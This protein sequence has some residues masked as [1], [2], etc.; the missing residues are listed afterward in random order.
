MSIQ[1]SAS[2][3]DDLV[4]PL[5]CFKSPND[6]LTELLPAPLF[7]RGVWTGYVPLGTVEVCISP[8]QRE[9]RFGFRVDTCVT[10]SLARVVMAA[11][12]KH[13]GQAVEVLLA[14]CTGSMVR[15]RSL[16][17]AAIRNCPLD[18]Y[19][20]W[21]AR[22][23]RAPEPDGLEQ[24]RS[25][26]RQ[27]PHIR[28]IVQ[29]DGESSPADIDATL[30]S[31]RRQC[32]VNWSLAAVCP[33]QHRRMAADVVAAKMGAEFKVDL[34]QP[35]SPVEVLWSAVTDDVLLMP[36][37]AG[38]II[39]SFG[40]SVLAEYAVAHPDIEIIY[41]DEDSAENGKYC[42]PKLKPDWSPTFQRC[43]HYVG[44]AVYA[45]SSIFPRSKGAVASDVALD[46]WFASSILLPDAQVGHL[47]RVLLTTRMHGQKQRAESPRF[48]LPVRRQIDQTTQQPSATIV[49]PNKDRAELLDACLE[50]LRLTRP[51]DFEIIVM[52]NGSKEAE[53]FA[54]Y[55]RWR[56]HPGFR[57]QSSPGPFNFSSLCNLAA[58][59]AR[60]PVLV[61]LNNDT[62]VRTPDW[63]STMIYWTLRPEIGAVGTKLI[64]PSGQLQ[65][66]GLVIGLGGYAAHI[67]RGALSGQ[68]G[69]LGRLGA[70]REVSAV[71]AACMAVERAKFDFV[72]GF[73]AHRFPVEFNDTDLCLRL[74]VAGWATI[75]LVEP[76]LIHHESATRGHTLDMDTRYE[77]ERDYF[78]DR[79]F[80][81]IRDD[82]FFH[83]ALSLHTVATALDE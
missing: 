36:L 82:P 4:R 78:R 41:A 57:V 9:G 16:I 62:V 12:T 15:A 58:A 1:Y 27:G 18:S 72:G 63:L 59:V 31:L 70:A 40:L 65:H 66:A 47:R 64:Y 6:E 25:D 39:P 51:L 24:S 73:D 14:A 44:R 26:R 48:E 68:P 80:Q 83:P 81:C 8:V 42:N 29:L 77:R 43:T 69:Y 34:V 32:Y 33:E 20:S 52:D 75:C 71:T 17:Q 60:S 76:V 53:T 28:I 49:I 46:A 37:A 74:S 11:L 23:L 19:D 54:L 5:I 55:E 13:P 67:D 2:L 22:R 45:R 21:R 50:S 79:W 30:S 56:D 38:D 10:L 35:D 7:G 61:F 3:Y